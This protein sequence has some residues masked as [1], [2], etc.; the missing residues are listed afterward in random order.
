MNYPPYWGY[1]PHSPIFIPP[2]QKSGMTLEDILLAERALK[3]LRDG[4]K[5]EADEKKKKDDEKKGKMPSFSLGGLLAALSIGSIPMVIF[6]L[7]L[8]DWARTSI[9]P[10]LKAP[11]P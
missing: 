10:F 11:I 1:P 2:Q 7:M 4:F 9:A 6:Q 3:E 5:K 8:L